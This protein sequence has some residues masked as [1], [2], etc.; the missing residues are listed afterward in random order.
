M[1]RLCNVE[2]IGGVLKVETITSPAMSYSV[3]EYKSGYIDI[4]K[5]GYEAL[6]VVG[7][8]TG[9]RIIMAPVLIITAPNTL[10][11]GMKNT[12]TAET[13]SNRSFTVHILYQKS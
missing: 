2:K 5:S 9:A 3:N 10:Y 7:V 11:Y 6:G 13:V 12:S 1:E 8:H 4:S